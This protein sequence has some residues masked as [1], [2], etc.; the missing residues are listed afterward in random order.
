MRILAIE[1]S[2]D[3]TAISILE[4]EGEL[5]SAKFKVLSHVVTSQIAIHAPYGGVVPNLAKREHQINLPLVLEQALAQAQISDP[6]TIDLLAVTSGPGLEPA[7]WTGITFAGELSQS[8]QKPLIPINHME[9]HLVSPLLDPTS[10][11]HFPALALLISGGH[12]ELILMSDWL[13]YQVVG[14]TRDDAVGEAFDKVARLLDLPYP[15]GPAL[16]KLA[17]EQRT[18]GRT[19]RWRLPRPMLHSGD[20]DFSF[21]GLKTAVLYLIKK[22]QSHPHI[23]AEFKLS[24]EAK[25]DIAREFEDAA[26]EVLLTKS[27]KA[28]ENYNIQT[29]IIGGGV[30]ANETLRTAFSNALA[31]KYPDTN[32]LI[33]EFKLATDNATMIGMAAYLHSR[34]ETPTIAPA[35]T[36]QGNLSLS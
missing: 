33:P 29:L 19:P 10:P 30:I 23:G 20:L 21:S 32:L 35:I 34:R 25:E 12:T 9:G 16:A 4:A 8:W 28:I 24:D 2:C 18:S 14:R 17:E 3:E 36:A 1:T 5:G 6:Q 26:I 11:I 15:G 22:Q 31:D 27:L 13:K 7:L